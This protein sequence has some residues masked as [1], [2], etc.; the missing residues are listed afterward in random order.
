MGAFRKGSNAYY[1]PEKVT[2]I[3]S[4][5]PHC[6]MAQ[7]VSAKNAENIIH[8]PSGGIQQSSM[9]VLVDQMKNQVYMVIQSELY[10][11]DTEQMTTCNRAPTTL[12]A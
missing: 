12:P 11:E 9:V 2:K 4:C 6:L 8:L 10:S 1:E 7:H 5:H 3:K